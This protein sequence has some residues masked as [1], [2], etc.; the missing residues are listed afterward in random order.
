MIGLDMIKVHGET[1]DTRTT[2][3]EKVEFMGVSWV[4]IS[5]KMFPEERF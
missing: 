4:K 3:T 5:N 1:V 2:W